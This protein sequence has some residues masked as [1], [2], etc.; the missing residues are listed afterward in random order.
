MTRLLYEYTVP[1]VVASAAATSRASR[2][3]TPVMW[4]ACHSVGETSARTRSAAQSKSRRRYSR[5]NSADGSSAAGTWSIS[6]A[7]VVSPVPRT[8]RSRT[9]RALIV[10]FRAIRD[11]QARNDPRAGSVSNRSIAA[12]TA[13]KTSC[14]RSIASASCSPRRRASR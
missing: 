2:P 8:C 1:T 12:A 14:V 3:S 13:R 11:S 7:T 5:S 10:R 6:R 9:A 4:N